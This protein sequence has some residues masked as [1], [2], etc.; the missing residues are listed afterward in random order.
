MKRR[1]AIALLGS[2]AAAWPLAA[3]AQQSRKS[4]RI[5]LISQSPPNDRATGRRERLWSAFFEE[6]ARLGYAEGKN[7]AVDWRDSAGDTHHARALARDIAAMAPDAVFTPD[8]RMAAELKTAAPSLPIVAIF[9]DPVSFGIAASLARPGGNVTGFSIDVG[10]EVGR[11]RVAWL[12]EAVP[13]ISRMAWLTPRRHWQSRFR[14]IVKTSAD[15]AGLAIV[16]AV[17][18][19]PGEEADYRRA[20]AAAAREKADAINV[21]PALENLTQRRLI[22][23]LALEQRLP[24]M[25]AYRENAEAGAMM[26]YAVDLAHMFR[27]AAEY[28]GRI[29][30]GAHPGSLPIQQPTKFE[31]IVNL[32]TAKALRLTLPES[33]LSRADTVIE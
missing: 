9:A 32:V 30:D 19:P 22:A 4:A 31:L 16:G 15:A 13:H 18:D 21:S 12:K 10:P 2:A 33:V 8:Q 11:K 23:A 5:A 29:L 3:G 28:V 26:A 14:D 6:L 24:A 1:D 7:L 27:G 17:V 20:F 25:C